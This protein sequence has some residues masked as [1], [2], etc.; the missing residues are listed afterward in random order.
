MIFQF[1]L[2]I[3]NLSYSAPVAHLLEQRFNRLTKPFVGTFFVE[4]NDGTESIGVIDVIDS[5]L[6][7]R[8]ARSRM[9]YNAGEIPLELSAGGAIQRTD[10]YDYMGGKV[11]I[12]SQVK[13]AP[14][15]ILL[16]ETV[17]SSSAHH[18]KTLRLNYRNGIIN[19]H[20]ANRFY[21]RRY[22]FW[23]QWVVDNSSFN[24]KHNSIRMDLTMSKRSSYAIAYNDLLKIA[25]SQPEVYY[26]DPDSKNASE[27]RESI[28][29][30]NA[31]LVRLDARELNRKSAIR[32]QVLLFPHRINCQ[33]YFAK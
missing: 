5:K 22:I 15:E 33:S 21:K 31:N 3:L 6:V 8:I 28:K 1:L 20:L 25:R 16:T 14:N 32:G 29:S 9:V 2:L 23:G 13:L 30:G 4:L 12:T 24:A 26:R 10:Y 17:E 27:L 11:N 7:I 19:Y 18:V